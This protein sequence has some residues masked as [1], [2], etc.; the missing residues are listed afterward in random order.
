MSGRRLTAW[1]L[2]LIV[3]MPFI[4]YAQDTTTI[5][6]G[7]QV[8]GEI[9]D[10]NFEVPFDFEG[11]EGDVLIAEMKPVDS[12]GDLN[13]PELILINSEGDTVADTSGSFSFGG[14]LLAVQLPTNDTYT[15]LASRSD[16]RAGD[17]VGEFTLALINPTIL[18]PKE[19][20]TGT[21]S[22]AEGATYYMIESGK[23]PYNLS[24]QKLDGEFS[25][26]VSVNVINEEGGLSSVINL[27]G[28]FLSNVQVSIPESEVPIIV[29]ISEAAFDFNF[30]EVT[31][32]Y[33][34]L[35]TA[36]E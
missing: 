14:A 10:R 27:N 21:A 15:I 32:E 24:Y 29:K 19:S 5:E 4:V 3:L 22:S 9:T 35:I 17:S 30:D 11:K 23:A 13:S 28:S 1:I 33:E 6:Y 2:A 7:Q 36:D 34:L 16:G 8:S 25:P 18:K 20:L 26:E 12:L 31:A